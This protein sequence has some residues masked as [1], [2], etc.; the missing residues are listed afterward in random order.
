MKDKVIEVQKE[1]P[2]TRAETFSMVVNS[3]NPGSG[4]TGKGGDPEFKASLGYTLRN[5]EVNKS[6]SLDDFR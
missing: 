4:E 3:Y 2:E 1:Q 5:S 6:Q